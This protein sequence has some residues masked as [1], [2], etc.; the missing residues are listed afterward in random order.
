[1]A[2][3]LVY[4]TKGT[5]IEPLLSGHPRGDGKWWVNRGWPFDMGLSQTSMRCGTKSLY[6]EIKTCG[7]L[8]KLLP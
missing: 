2:V 1:M 5:T 8:W 3:I 7:D 6:L 4:V